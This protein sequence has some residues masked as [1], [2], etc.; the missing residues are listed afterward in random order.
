MARPLSPELTR[1][2]HAFLGALLPAPE[3]ADAFHDVVAE[4]Q[5]WREDDRLGVLRI[6]RD[7]LAQRVRVEEDALV[8]VLLAD[9]GLAADD[10]VAAVLELSVTGAVAAR[11]RIEALVGAVADPP[12]PPAAR[13][14]V[15][16]PE[17]APD[18]APLRIGFDDDEPL[19]LA[20]YENRGARRH[21][22]LTSILLLWV[23]IA[24]LVFVVRG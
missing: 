14:A 23:V 3:V 11:E 9:V 16:T 18:G 22:W 2:V 21:W 17:A 8:H 24:F 7:V 12:P 20:A 10:E 1:D 13:A 5:Y 4:V 6:T 19:N 15:A